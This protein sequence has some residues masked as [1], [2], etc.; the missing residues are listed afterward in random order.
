MIWLYRILFPPLMLLALPRYFYRMWKRGGYRNGFSNRFGRMQNIPPK[1]P[2]VKRIWIQAV[3]VG[4]TLAI[5]PLLKSLH[6]QG[7]QV[8]LTVTTSTALQLAQDRL[9]DR[10]AW[11]GVFP[12]D[13]YFFSR[14]AW[15]SL[16][17]DLVLL[18]ETELWPEHLRQA[19]IRKVPVLLINARLSDRSFSRF[20]RF[21]GLARPLFGNLNGVLASTSQDLQR[22]ET[23]GWGEHRELTGN[24]KFDVAVQ[25]PP[26]AQLQALRDELLQTKAESGT[27]WILGAS[28]WP[29]EERALVQACKRIRAEGSGDVQLILTP[30]HA[31][32]RDDIERE[33]KEEKVPF[34]FRSRKRERSAENWVYVADTTGELRALVELADIAFVGKSM[35][36]HREGQTPIEA[37]AAGKAIV[38]GPGMSNFREASQSISSAGAAR[39][40]DTVGELYQVLKELV[41]N[42]TARES[43]GLAGKSLFRANAGA[44]EKVL[45]AINARLRS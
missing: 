25:T 38:M 28:T 10:C 43:M 14:A 31:E 18:T 4:E 33:L 9:R 3:S 30:R 26:E 5:Q 44:T 45:D 41:E 11:I 37:A 17:P 13:F 12:T 36:P 7:H 34:Q 40:V 2:G 15:N 35:P 16:Q 42:P 22:F 27:V 24:L 8:F 39:I 20:Q 21:Q 32:R 19:R 29:G 1:P 6:D 23:L